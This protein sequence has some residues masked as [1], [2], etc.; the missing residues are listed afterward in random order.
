MPVPGVAPEAELEEGA[1]VD[2]RPPEEIQGRAASA[3]AIAKV[4]VAKG[5]KL[6]PADPV[7]NNRP[8]PVDASVVK[9]AVDKVKVPRVDNALADRAALADSNEPVGKEGAAVEA[10]VLIPRRY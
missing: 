4:A 8:R 1:A 3:P 2:R 7:A 9:V 10:V 6:H 5:P